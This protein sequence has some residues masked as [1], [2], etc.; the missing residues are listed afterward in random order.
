VKPDLE[1]LQKRYKHQMAGLIP[2]LE[3]V[4]INQESPQ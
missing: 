2:V 4:V 1:K 3:E